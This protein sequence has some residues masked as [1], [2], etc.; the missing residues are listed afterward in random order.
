MDTE[1][2][3]HQPTTH[4]G[5]GAHRAEQRQTADGKA[6]DLGLGGRQAGLRFGVT[7]GG[8]DHCGNVQPLLREVEN[9]LRQLAEL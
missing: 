6:E 9:K 8:G 7:Q 4:P 5:Y 2:V 1:V 3:V